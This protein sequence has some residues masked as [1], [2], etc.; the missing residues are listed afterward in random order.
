VKAF[1]SPQG[2][3]NVQ[4]TRVRRKKR[5]RK[6]FWGSSVLLCNG[7]GSCQMV[8][9]GGPL[10]YNASLCTLAQHNNRG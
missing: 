6:R 10:I 8:E 1:Q 3:K 9:K 4:F 5:C 7:A 2:N